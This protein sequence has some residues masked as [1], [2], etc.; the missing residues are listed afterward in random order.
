MR[1]LDRLAIKCPGL[2]YK[3]DGHYYF[4]DPSLSLDYLVSG[5]K[6]NG[7]FEEF[8]IRGRLIDDDIALDMSF[9]G[10]IG[11]GVLTVPMS[12]NLSDQSCMDLFNHAIDITYT[13]Y[14][15]HDNTVRTLYYDKQAI[16]R[17]Y[18]IAQII[19]HED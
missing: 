12:L 1:P 13:V 5:F 6:M 8:S 7:I 17:R 15:L 9:Y 3:K 2:F 10:E 14:T 18:N 11:Q 16:I 4:T 19:N